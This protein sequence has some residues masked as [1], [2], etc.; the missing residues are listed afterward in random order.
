MESRA[1]TVPATAGC[2][3]MELSASAARQ[4]LHLQC[5]VTSQE[6]PNST[7]GMLCTAANKRNIR[8]RSTSM[9]PTG[10]H[11]ALKSNSSKDKIVLQRASLALVTLGLDHKAVRVV[12]ST[13]AS[14]KRRLSHD[15][16]CRCLCFLDSSR[17]CLE[18]RLPFSKRHRCSNKRD[19]HACTHIHTS[20]RHVY[21]Q[22]HT[23]H[24]H[25]ETHPQIHT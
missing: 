23:A 12:H 16:H 6:A 10:S 20:Y 11:H 14:S 13:R 18:E 3:G 1:Q 19:I 17:R 7:S 2:D 9:S 8:W 22:I 25:T 24:A 4:S 5:C 15:R 21:T